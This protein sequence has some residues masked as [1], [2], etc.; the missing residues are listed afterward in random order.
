MT[1]IAPLLF[2]GALLRS[3]E[4]KSSGSP[5]DP[6]APASLCTATGWGGTGAVHGHV[7]CDLIVYGDT[8]QT[9]SLPG[10]GLFMQRDA[11]AVAAPSRIHSVP[12]VLYLSDLLYPPNGPLLHC[13]IYFYRTS[14]SPASVLLSTFFILQFHRV[15]QLV[16]SNINSVKIHATDWVGRLSGWACFPR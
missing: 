11:H 2:G 8:I 6:M 7:T 5:R 14:P 16:R 12:A 13:W 3:T 10:N 15:N 9:P 4:T 1:L